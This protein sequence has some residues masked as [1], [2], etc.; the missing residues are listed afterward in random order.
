MSGEVLEQRQH[1][2]LILPSSL[3]SEGDHPRAC[4]AQN[5]L[6]AHKWH[7]S[8]QRSAPRRHSARQPAWLRAGG[9]YLQDPLCQP[10]TFTPGP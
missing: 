4:C 10:L 3:G 6:D 8:C 9:K 5:L 2:L 1:T 7:T